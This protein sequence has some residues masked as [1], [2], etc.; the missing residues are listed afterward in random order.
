MTAVRGSVR[1][2]HAMGL[3]ARPA[4]KLARLA[5]S[6]AAEIHIRGQPNGAWVDAKSV[7][8][9]LE[10]KLPSETTIEFKVTG[11]AAD[12]VLSAMTGLVARDFDE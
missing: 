12:V 6:F 3:H 9:V 10:L 1:I 4:V 7:V 2:H 11:E 5:K 8:K